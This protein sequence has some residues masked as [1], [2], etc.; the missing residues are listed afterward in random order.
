MF[1]TVG[2]GLRA[3][4]CNIRVETPCH[5]AHDTLQR[6]LFPS[7]KRTEYSATP[8]VLFCVERRDD[9]FQLS[10]N[11]VEVALA[12]SAINLA[13]AAIKALD[14][15]VVKRLA[16]LRAVHAGA[17]LFANRAML[18]PGSTHAGKSSLVAELLKRGATY[19]SDEYAL[20]DEEG[21]VHPYPRPLL[22]RN[23]R[24]RQ[25]PVLPGDLNASFASEPAP[26]GW[27]LSLEYDAVNTWNIQAIPQGEALMIL[28]RNTPHPLEESPSMTDMFLRAV[29]TA[30]CYCGQRGD[31]VQAADEI[32]ELIAGTA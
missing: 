8:D 31:A 19:L 5:D 10:V 20:I 27:I 9:K 7:I 3:F 12:D 11:G 17:V 30:S 15:I 1:S 23:G 29:A 14:D 6:Y 25:V 13:V 32:L 4:D 18:I 28:L 26:V 16:T 2:F 24:P 21:Y 22:L